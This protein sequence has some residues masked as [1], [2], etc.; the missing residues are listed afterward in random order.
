MISSRSSAA[1]EKNSQRV[2]MNHYVKQMEQMVT[3]VSS[4]PSTVENYSLMEK[5]NCQQVNIMNAN[6]RKCKYQT[7]ENFT[8]NNCLA[9]RKIRGPYNNGRK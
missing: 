1:M 2:L 9:K 6:G 4:F 3:N 5:P 7:A 8:N